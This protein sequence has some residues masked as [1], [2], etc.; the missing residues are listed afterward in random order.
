MAPT[1]VLLSLSFI[2][3]LHRTIEGE[4]HGAGSVVS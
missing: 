2:N 1:P 4:I 3:S